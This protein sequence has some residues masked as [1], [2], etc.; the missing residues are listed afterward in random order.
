[1]FGYESPL[2]TLGNQF[3]PDWIYFDKV[4]L[5]DRVSVQFTFLLLMYKVKSPFKVGY[6][7]RSYDRT[8]IYERTNE[9]ARVLLQFMNKNSMNKRISFIFSSEPDDK[10]YPVFFYLE[11][12]NIPNSEIYSEFRHFQGEFFKLTIRIV[13]LLLLQP[14]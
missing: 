9:R 13:L 7:Y 10:S 8:S 5:I 14:V 4:G 2:T 1:M 12:K 11:N 3:L 6:D